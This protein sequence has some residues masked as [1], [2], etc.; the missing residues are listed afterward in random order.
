MRDF[1]S[2]KK[3]LP[4]RGTPAIDEVFEEWVPNDLLK[5]KKLRD[6]QQLT[7]RRVAEL[8]SAAEQK[9]ASV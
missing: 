7:Q 9:L 4:L 2:V 6:A 5:M 3:P 8:R 1:D